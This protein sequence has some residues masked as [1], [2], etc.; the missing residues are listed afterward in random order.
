MYQNKILILFSS[1]V[2]CECIVR[3]KYS[4]ILDMYAIAIE[5]H[6]FFYL[7]NKMQIIIVQCTCVYV[8]EGVFMQFQNG[9]SLHIK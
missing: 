5:F 4:R 6:S 3:C 8:G 2:F 1:I 7:C 9:P